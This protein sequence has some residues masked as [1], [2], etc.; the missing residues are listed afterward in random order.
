MARN[1]FSCIAA[2]ATA[3]IIAL[4][5]SAFAETVSIT[6]PVELTD[7]AIPGQQMNPS[8]VVFEDVLYVFWASNSAETPIGSD[9]DIT[10]STYD[11]TEWSQNIVITANDTGNDHT[12][13]PVIFRDS[14]YLLWSSTN[15]AITG[16]SDADIVV[17]TLSGN[18]WS[19]P[20]SVTSE[21][22]ST[23][24]YDPFPVVYGGELHIFFE[25]FSPQSSHYEIGHAVLSDT[26]GSPNYMTENS[27]GHNLNPTAAVAEQ[28]LVLAWESSSSSLT[29]SADRAIISKVL[30]GNQ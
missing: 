23:G 22:N 15:P 6:P 19:A 29:G 4:P 30:T 10:Y 3:L 9:F 2:L 5:G 7:D 17:S 25:C 20:L 16:S 1:S 13:K 11:G 26:W 28:S 14:L 8:S 24:D 12:P 27:T 18:T 21:F